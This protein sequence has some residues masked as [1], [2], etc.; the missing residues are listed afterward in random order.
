MIITKYKLWL[1]LCQKV[2][3]M[4]SVTIPECLSAKYKDTFAYKTIAD[5]L[6]IIMTKAIDS[7]CRQVKTLVDLGLVK[8]ENRVQ[9]EEEMK[10]SIG[11]I[12]KLRNELMTDKPFTELVSTAPDVKIWN[13]YLTDY[14]KQFGC[15]PKWFECEWL[16]AECY[17]YRRTREAFEVTKYVNKF[18]PFNESKEQAL[19][20][21]IKAIEVLADFMRKI[22]YKQDFNI[23]DQ[24]IRFIE[25][26]LW[27]NKCDLSLS[28][29]VDST[30][31]SNPT[32]DLVRMRDKIIVNQIK[33]LWNYVKT[34]SDK[35]DL[36]ISVV[37]D[38]SGFEL[39]TDLCLIEFLSA[40]HLLTDKSVV[41]FYVK[42]MPWFV[43]DVM[44]KDFHWFLNYLSNDS[45]THS[46]VVKELAKK[47]INNLESGKWVIIDDQFWTLPHDF[48][49]MKT[50]SP[51]LYKSL[52]ESQL[53]IFKGDLNYRKL[54]GDLNWDLSVP[55]KTA[56]RGFLP[57]TVC[58][59][60]TI[61]AD[62]V[63]G[64][65]DKQM[66]EKIK[67]FPKDWRETGDYALIQM[68]VK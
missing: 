37:L 27:G 66:L 1:H 41:R 3:T 36:Q 8:P 15:E 35:K 49:H 63:V 45:N 31:F 34:C 62:V 5:R 64:V 23:E 65:E 25:L 57:T 11:R 67:S 21:S 58:T 17:L 51:D 22:T 68:A 4:S 6:P 50:V 18:D 42:S 16:Y 28:A 46:T 38:N 59:L 61:K 60:R 43:S 2:K 44:T 48:S 26:S 40:S 39:F 7:T 53:I 47:W 30:R 52:G 13:Q 32:D 12:A 56:L 19:K 55:F 10:D 24:F 14:K 20:S 29:G 9:A 33:E 54:A